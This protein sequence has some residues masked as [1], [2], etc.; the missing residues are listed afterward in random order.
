MKKDCL[1]GRVRANSLKMSMIFSH[2]LEI[3]DDFEG[4]LLTKTPTMSLLFCNR[5]LDNI[6]H[7]TFPKENP[8]QQMT[9]IWEYVVFPREN[10]M[11]H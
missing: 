1:D 7:V 10:G 4:L 9:P 5:R 6:T 11:F 8:Q 3:L 2:R